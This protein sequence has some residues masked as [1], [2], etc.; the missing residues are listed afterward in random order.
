[1]EFLSSDDWGKS[2]D[3]DGM[4]TCRC[5]LVL[6]ENALRNKVMQSSVVIIMVSLVH[7]S[8]SGRWGNCCPFM[9][10]TN[11]T[12]MFDGNRLMPEVNVSTCSAIGAQQLINIVSTST[13]R[14]FISSWQYCGSLSL[15]NAALSIYMP[16]SMN[17][18]ERRCCW[19]VCWWPSR[20]LQTQI[21]RVAEMNCVGTRRP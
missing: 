9:A 13:C 18:N 6:K 20:S 2:L 8:S 10:H 17:S 14:F 12:R 3:P 16:L 5:Q 4:Q 1:M 7:V 11:C 15:T 19:S 21:F